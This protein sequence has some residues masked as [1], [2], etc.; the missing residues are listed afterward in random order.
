MTSTQL[1]SLCGM[2]SGQL[3]NS[4]PSEMVSQSEVI[5]HAYCYSQLPH[6]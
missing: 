1:F 3:L 2:E 6:V 4:Y 5:F